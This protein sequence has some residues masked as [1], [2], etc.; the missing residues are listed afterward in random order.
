MNKIAIVADSSQDLTFELGE[1]YGIEILS[2][3]VQMDD[4]HYKDLVDID[5]QYFYDHMSQHKVLSTGIPPIQEVFDKF[6]Q[7]K[8]EGYTQAVV[9]TSSAKITGMRQLMQVVADQVEGIELFIIDSRQVAGSAGLLAIQAAQLRDQGQP[10][11]A[12]V[13]ELE[14]L[15]PQANIFALFRTLEYVVRG[16]RFNKYKGMLGTLLNI[17]PLLKAVDGEV[18]VIDKARGNK[19]SLQRLVNCVRD[20]IGS[21][22]RY[23]LFIFSGDNPE[24]VAQLRD[25]L[26]D[27]IAR[28]DLVIET[29]LTAV[30]GVHAGPKSIGVSTLILD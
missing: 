25:D 6:D 8:E 11:Q 16:G 10:A 19:K 18:G 15:L 7:L 24:E 4:N 13:E 1:K 21:A 23:R 28:A 22:Q 29:Q 27:V 26:A 3:Y 2:Y 9:I 14:R 20:E 5:T 30:L 12:I 17:H